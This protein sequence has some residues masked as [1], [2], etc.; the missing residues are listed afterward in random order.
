MSSRMAVAGREGEDATASR[1]AVAG[2]SVFT[3]LLD[4]SRDDRFERDIGIRR[5]DGDGILAAAAG[6]DSKRV[7]DRKRGGTSLDDLVDGVIGFDLHHDSV[8]EES[9]STGSSDSKNI[10]G[11]TPARFAADNHAASPSAR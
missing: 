6:I 11:T 3:G 7:H 9:C 2:S 4:D 5:R 10:E 8:P 1:A